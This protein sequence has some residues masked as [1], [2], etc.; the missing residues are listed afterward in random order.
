MRSAVAWALALAAEFLVGLCE[1]HDVALMV[2]RAFF[3]K[4]GARINRRVFEIKGSRDDDRTTVY[5]KRYVIFQSDIFRIYCHR[6]L[7]SDYPVFHDHPWSATFV[8]L[9]GSY[10]EEYLVAADSTYQSIWGHTGSGWHRIESTKR[11]LL[12]VT[13]IGRD[14]IHR[15]VLDREYHDE[16][17]LAPLT[18][19]FS[20]PRAKNADGEDD[21]GFWVDDTAGGE[22]TYRLRTRVHWKKHLGVNRQNAAAKAS[23]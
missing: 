11:K 4:A 23:H 7:R 14:H 18:I 20:G 6:F 17:H 16:P 12:E 9:R 22:A 1:L 13:R 5:L 8:Q 10:T 19:A 3:P 21:W 2:F 15:V